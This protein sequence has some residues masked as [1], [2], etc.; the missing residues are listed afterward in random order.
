MLL[1]VAA[2]PAPARQSTSAIGLEALLGREAR[3][4]TAYLD[5]VG[6]YTIGIG[7]TVAAGAPFRARA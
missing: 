2:A 7:H 5:S 3:R 4:Q 1:P 6:V